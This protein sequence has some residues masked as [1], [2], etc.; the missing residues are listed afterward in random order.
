MAE[1]SAEPSGGKSK[2]AFW[3]ILIVLLVWLGGLASLSQVPS[4]PI[5]NQYQIRRAD[6]V[7]LAV[8]EDVAKKRVRVNKVW[9]GKAPES[10]VIALTNLDKVEVSQ[11]AEYVMAL[12]NDGR[13]VKI[14]DRNKPGSGGPVVYPNTEAVRAQ[15]LD[16]LESG[17]IRE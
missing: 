12:W 3:F 13:I 7:V 11:G 9:S 10:D 2:L 8:P 16:A 14:S 1:Q 15:V 17:R 6:L 5:V 4:T